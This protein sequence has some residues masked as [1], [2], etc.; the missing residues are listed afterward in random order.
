MDGK[1]NDDIWFLTNNMKKMK[2]YF[3]L[4]AFIVFNTLF[5]QHFNPQ[6]NKTTQKFFPDFNFEI[7]THALKKTGFT[8]Y[9]EMM[10]FLNDLVS[11]H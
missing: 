3:I 4:T 6:N 1:N 11:K 5:G 2:K 8:K 10:Y 7:N 9:E